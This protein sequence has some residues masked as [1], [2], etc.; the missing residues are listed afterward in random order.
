MDEESP[1]KPVIAIDLDETKVADADLEPLKIFTRLE[2]LTL[3]HTEIT[4]AGVE[5]LKDLSRLQV[6]GLWEPRSPTPDWPIL[7]S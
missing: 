5:Y 3:N 2:T 4:D 1:S 7:K 6:L